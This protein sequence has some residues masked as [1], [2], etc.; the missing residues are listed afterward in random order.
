[1]DTQNFLTLVQASPPAVVSVVSVYHP[2]LTPSARPLPLAG[3][4]RED[5]YPGLPVRLSTVS[6]AL[7]PRRLYLLHKHACVLHS[8]DLTLC[9]LLNR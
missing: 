3:L 6:S 8:K 9:G 4:A 1:M 5:G 2:T 7:R